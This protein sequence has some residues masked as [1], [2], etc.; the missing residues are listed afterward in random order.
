MHGGRDRR[1]LA[2]DTELAKDRRLEIGEA[3][4]LSRTPALPAD[5]DRAHDAEIERLHIL[6][7]QGFA[8]LDE[9]PSGTICGSGIR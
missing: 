8:M 4:A 5:C 7:L 3:G 1:R 9:L 6:E 2:D